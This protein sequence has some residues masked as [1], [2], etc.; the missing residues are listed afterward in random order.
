MSRHLG[1]QISPWE[2]DIPAGWPRPYYYPIDNPDDNGA[3]R[4]KPLFASWSSEVAAGQINSCSSNRT[5]T[6][7][8]YNLCSSCGQGMVRGLVFD[9][10]WMTANLPVGWETKPPSSPHLPSLSCLDEH[11]THYGSPICYRCAVFAVKH[12]PLFSFFDDVWGDALVWLVVTR[13]DQYREFDESSAIELVDAGSLAQVTTGDVRADVA[14]GRFHLMTVGADDLPLLV[15]PADYDTD[16]P[17]GSAVT[18]PKYD[19]TQ[20]NRLGSGSGKGL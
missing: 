15:R 16:F 7:G 9:R 20:V 1:R 8:A 11:D 12:C 14:G 17:D 5:W 4:G 19:P 13:A 3:V 18:Q 2:E 6:A 10:N